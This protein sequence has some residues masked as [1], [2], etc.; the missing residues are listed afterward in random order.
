MIARLLSARV[1]LTVGLVSLVTSSF[2]LIS[3]FGLFPD[4]NAMTRDARLS[5]S[6]LIAASAMSGLASGDTVGTNELLAFITE[7]R[8]DL[9]SV[10]IRQAGGN[11]VSRAGDHTRHW[12]GALATNSTETDIIVPLYSGGKKWGQAEL[13]FAPL[14]RD[15]WLSFLDDDR[16]QLAIALGLLCFAGFYFFLGRMLKHLDPSRAVPARVRN[17]LDTLAESLLLIDN[18]RQVVLANQSF[19][20]LVGQQPDTLLGKPDKLFNWMDKSGD[21]M[22]ED[23]TPWSRALQSGELQRNVPVSLVNAL[24]Q[25]RSF[26]ANCSP[27]AGA[28]KT[29]NGVLIS[30]DDVTELEEKEIQLNDAREKAESANQA[31]SEFLANMSHE[32]RT[33]MNAV[34]GFTELMRRNGGRS[35]SESAQYLETISRNGKQLLALINDILDLSKVESGEF[36]TEQIPTGAHTVAHEVI[37]VLNVRAK[38]KNIGLRFSAVGDVPETILADP[39]RLRQVITNLVGNAIKFT[40]DGEVV[41]EEQ[42]ENNNTGQWLHLA[43]R[44]SG[45]GIP[46]EKLPTIFEPFTQAESSTTR[47]FGGTGL[48]LT[49]SRKF[50]RAMGGDI[51]VTSSF[52]QGS[53][54]R[55]S[56]PVGIAHDQLTMISASDAMQRTASADTGPQTGWRF[57]GQRILVV[58]DSPENRELVGVVLEESGLQIDMATNGQEACEQALANSYD[59]ILMDMQM[60]VMDGYAAT[61]ELRRAGVKTTIYAFTAHALSGFD[62]EINEVGCDG[63]LTKPIDIDLM[64]ETL[65]KLLGGREVQLDQQPVVEPTTGTTTDTTD[66]AG[67]TEDLATGAPAAA[68]DASAQLLAP[69]ESRLAGNVRLRNIIAAF[70]ERMPA[71]VDEMR[72]AIAQ[73]DHDKLSKLA[74]WLKGSGGSVGFD[75]F[76][77]PARLLEE[78][79]KTQNWSEIPAH[80][81]PIEN[82]ASRIIAPGSEPVESGAT[83]TATNEISEIQP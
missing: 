42:Y 47:R 38:E 70:V 77:E 60:P 30:L 76:T 36:E 81:R 16:I 1:M 53:E 59:L 63:Y 17:A 39:A 26:L 73:H 54:F 61:A 9:L 40:E 71:Q 74:H 8:Q 11:I 35:A 22:P 79:A 32:I 6:E 46:A 67:T 48:G 18:K 69:I 45:I 14:G 12:R 75:N 24:G 68:D 23:Q 55:V 10:A 4:R 29:I 3:F 7:R 37:E 65:G 51:R 2:L 13:A 25:R 78:A 80:F 33:P 21:P 19:A 15:S 64:L 31:K 82:L 28:E 20:D 34:L 5:M 57:D 44:D 41:V 52:G 58:D 56:L 27:I 49:I 43:I 62:K 83:S 72:N 66:P 50:A